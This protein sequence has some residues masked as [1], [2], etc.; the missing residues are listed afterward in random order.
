MN[1]VV[2]FHVVYYQLHSDSAMGQHVNAQ[3]ESDSEYVR[4]LYK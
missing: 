3:E 4:A 1:A 2:N